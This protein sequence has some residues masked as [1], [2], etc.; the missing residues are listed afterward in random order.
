MT[1]ITGLLTGSVATLLAG[2]LARRLTQ[3]PGSLPVDI[4]PF[5]Q[6][7]NLEEVRTAFN[8]ARFDEKFD[9][10]GWRMGRR[11]DLH[12]RC[13]LRARIAESRVYLERMDSNALVIQRHA[14]NAPQRRKGMRRDQAEE[15]RERILE[16]EG[17]LEGAELFERDA[18][19]PEYSAE[20][21][22]LR[23]SAARLRSDAEKVLAEDAERKK[24]ILENIKK[25]DDAR[26]ATRD[27]RR[28]AGSQ[29]LKIN[30]LTL[31]LRFDKWSIVST[32]RISA[33]WLN[34][35]DNVLHLYERAK[36]RAAAYASLYQEE[37]TIQAN[38]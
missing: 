25:I 14:D 15:S 16:A 9:H 13:D 18:A 28:A 7:V 17:M 10:W 6:R 2:R 38:M 1:G 27:F 34:G 22:E 19:L 29:L 30:L 21:D 5:L 32:A 20:A 33:W 24:E 3:F 35:I 8:G 12:L 11:L 26:C 4:D 23:S 37:E 31:V 36:D